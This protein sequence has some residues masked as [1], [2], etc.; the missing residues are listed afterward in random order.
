MKKTLVVLAGFTAFFAS[1]GFLLWLVG[2]A[3]QETKARYRK[4]P[5]MD[6]RI[7]AWVGSPDCEHPEQHLEV[8]GGIA[9]CRCERSGQ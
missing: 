7:N 4:A 9:I 8:E 1:V 2:K 3:E 6:R 5:C